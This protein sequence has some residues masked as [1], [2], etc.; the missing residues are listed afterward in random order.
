M[1][2]APPKPVNSV[3]DAIGNTPV[4]RLNHVVP[5]DAAEVYVKLEFFGP[6][7]SY[8]DRMALSMVEEA[9]RRGDLKPGM[10]IVEATGGSTG[11]SLAFVCAAKGYRFL[12][13]SSNAFSVE[14]LRTMTT[15]GA[16]LDIV[17]SPTGKVT[18]DLIPSMVRRAEELS[19]AEGHYYTNQFRNA[20]ALVGYGKIGKELVEQLSDGI[21]GFCG[22]VGTAGMFTGVASSLRLKHPSAKT[23]VLEPAESPMITKG[24]KG[25]H[26]VEGIGS[27]L[28][29]PHLDSSLYDEAR[30]I[31][32][33]EARAMCRR[34]AK[35]EGLLV[36]TSS[37]LNIFA[38]IQLAKELG[39]GKK[40]VTVAVDTGLKYL[41]GSLFA[42]E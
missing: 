41:N 37:G 18:G 23:V 21:D 5:K 32:E 1:T 20:D 40:V 39:P 11:S 16:E 8:K 22:A 35:E 13:V 33:A 7:G 31:P 15:F 12:A 30:A 36:G 2:F 29:P 27:G 14:K 17:H 42:D 34:L 9:E 38:A 6:T 4:V 24:E 3:L 26:G 28:I 10:T 19:K 25:S